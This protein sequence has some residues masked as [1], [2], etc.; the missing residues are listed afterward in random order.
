MPF[1]S[2]DSDSRSEGLS[3]HLL[4]TRLGFGNCAQ[5]AALAELSIQ[6]HR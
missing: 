1:E 2:I 6:S 3:G 4:C 5:D